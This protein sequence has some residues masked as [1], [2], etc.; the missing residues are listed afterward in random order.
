L[1]EPAGSHTRF[2]IGRLLGYELRDGTPLPALV[3]RY[4]APFC[5]GEGLD[6]CT[7]T[8][9]FASSSPETPP[10]D[11]PPEAAPAAEAATPEPEPAPATGSVLPDL[12]APEEAGWTL[13]RVPGSSPVALGAG[14]GSVA[15]LAAFCLSGQPF[16]AVSFAEPP[17]A[18]RV[19]LGFAFGSGAVEVAA[20]REETAGG[21][22]VV[23][24]SGTPVAAGLAGRDS[25][26]EL[27]V[28]GAAEG[29]LSLA[30]STRALRGAL[31]ACGGA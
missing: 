4:A 11:A 24:L 6:E 3:A 13:R 14:V 20:D 17:P 5:A 1:S 28:D 22:F 7:R 26:V 30:G 15:S 12:P 2:E 8:W 16:L 9:S 10:I 29:I 23:A 19:T 21:A 25:E 31:E 18:D 27:R